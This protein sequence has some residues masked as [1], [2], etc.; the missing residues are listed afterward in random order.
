MASKRPVIGITCSE[1]EAS[2]GAWQRPAAL[3]PASYVRAVES[4][5]GL[6]VL[7]PPQPL[8][9]EE[10]A[11][12]LARLDGLI[13]SGGND[14][15]PTYYGE[16][17][18]RE[19]VVAS[20]ARDDLELAAVSAAIESELPLLAICRGLQ[21]LNV[22]RGGSL[23][24]HLPD[25]VGHGEHSPIRDGYGAH[26]VAIAAGSKLASLLSWE[27]GPVPTHH[28]QGI[29]RVGE[30]LRPSAHASD[31]LVEALEDDSLPFLVGV[32]WHPEVGEDPALFVGLVE[33][34]RQRA[35]KRGA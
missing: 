25:V 23:I 18:H 2:W 8:S 3:L 30:G 29:A 11:E 26:E 24:Q 4:A 15:A 1:E 21:V 27:R 12:L 31:G 9:A 17:P 16:E 33:A 34:A 35:S 6:P 19:T 22:A 5:G 13:V 20:G 10:A 7:L 14:V 28:H 32:Q